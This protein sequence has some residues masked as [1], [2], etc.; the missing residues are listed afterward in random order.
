MVCTP[1]SPSPASPANAPSFLAVTTA[2]GV[3][4]AITLRAFLEPAPGQV[5]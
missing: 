4:G 1:G 2:G 3:A 5:K